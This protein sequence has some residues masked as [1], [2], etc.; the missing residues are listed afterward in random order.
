MADSEDKVF[1]ISTPSG[2]VLHIQAK[3]EQTALAGAQDWH[4]KNSSLW[5][6]IKDVPSGFGYGLEKGIAGLGSMLGPAAIAEQ[7]VGAPPIGV[8]PP[9]QQ[10]IMQTEQRG[11]PIAPPTSM[12]G[13]LAAKAGEMTA[14]NPM[15]ALTAPGATMLGAGLSS[16][17]SEIGKNIAPEGFQ[18]AGELA[19]GILGPG[20][21]GKAASGL[22]KVAG[23]GTGLLTGTGGKDLSGAYQTGRVGGEAGQV[24]RENLR[25]QVPFENAVQD[26]RFATGNLGAERE[27]HY[28][29]ALASL[30]GGD[31]MI[32]FEPID[33][34][35]KQSERI[36]TT[37]GEST[38]KS[39]QAVRE[40]IR[41]EVDRWKALAQ[42]DPRFQTVLGMDGLK[43][44]IGDIW[45]STPEGTTER[46]VAG[47][48]YHSVRDALGKASPAYG[49]AMSAYEKESNQLDEVKRTLSL[50]DS[51]TIDTALRKLQSTQRDN[52]NTNYGQRQ[53][54]VDVLEQHGAP[55]LSAAL[56]GQSLS[57][58]IPR[59]IARASDPIALGLM[60]ASALTL[61]PGAMASLLM[62]PLMSPRVAGEAAHGMGRI[63]GYFGLPEVSQRM[64]SPTQM[65]QTAQALMALK[66]MQGQQN[67]F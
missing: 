1:E 39:T 45:Q 63:S 47:E 64:K 54:L 27:K 3:D 12:G 44:S 38:S 22:G 46:K 26:A 59:G 6:S 21:A 32:P 31:K 5:Q 16:I 4:E 8:T 13:E 67:A 35:L 50:G 53:K 28:Q 34:A 42:Q 18:T 24:F 7:S 20:V 61:H 58:P 10:Q 25:Q 48:I 15:T 36:A 40:R 60:G 43:K 51:R 49:K 41:G 56:A 57:S 14:Y 17:G 11:L 37:Y 2:H 9:T 52:V 55:N 19:G 62:A 29:A 65:A 33:N 30:P 66:L 23:F